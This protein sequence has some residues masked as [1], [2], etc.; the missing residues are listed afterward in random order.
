[1]NSVE[2]LGFGSLGRP[3]V[4]H[5]AMT[6]SGDVFALSNA[7]IRQARVVSPRALAEPGSLSGRVLPGQVALGQTVLLDWPMDAANDASTVVMFSQGDIAVVLVRPD[8]VRIDP[9]YVG[10]HTDAEIIS[11]DDVLSM[12]GK[13]YRVLNPMPG[14]WKVEI[15]ATAAP[16]SGVVD[17][18][19]TGGSDSAIALSVAP[20]SEFISLGS[21]IELDATLVD[22]VTPI[23]G[24]EVTAVIAPPSGPSST[25]PLYDNGLNGD[26]A[27]G[28]G[29]YFGR[30]P[31][32]AES[33]IYRIAVTAKGTSPSFLRNSLTGVQVTANEI[34]PS[35]TNSDAGVDTNG[36]GLYEKL[37]VNVGLNVSRSGS[38]I[39]LARLRAADGRD[40]GQISQTANLTPAD[41][42]IAMLF[43][44]ASI[45]RQRADGPYTISELRVLALGGVT[46]QVMVQTNVY[47]TQAY[48]WRQFQRL[49]ITLGTF[50]DAGLD[51]NGNGQFDVLNV[52]FFVDVTNA[53]TYIVDARLTDL[54]GTEITRATGFY[55]LAAGESLLRLSFDGANIG[56]KGLDGPYLV[57]DLSV[58]LYTNSN[59]ETST[60]LAHQTNVYYYWQFEGQTP[61]LPP[62]ANAGGPYTGKVGVPV[63]F[64]GSGSGDPEGQ[65]LTYSWDF[66]DG[67][68]GSGV[69]PS[70]TYS[71]AGHY[72]VTLVVND[73]TFSSA[74]V[75]TT[76]DI[77]PANLPPVAN[78]GP[79]RVVE[80]EHRV[81]LNGTASY[82]PDGKIVMYKWTQVSG[83]WVRL[84]DANTAIA[85]FR[86]PKTKHRQTLTLVFALNVT[87]NAGATSQ[88]QVTITVKDDH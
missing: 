56:A 1:V 5:T 57:K 38:Y 51:T 27:A 23:P 39:F 6:S 60:S 25:I 41:T 18:M 11:L 46:H 3:P 14:L 28:D 4:S 29:V 75:T 86:A 7:V 16:A 20:R 73:G 50:V 2:A 59:I 77:A 32:A 31:S 24:A 62:T 76:V 33:G 10:G 45:A 44:G 26:I 13:G 43:D 49:P 74:P 40:L 88:D 79:D 85:K 83:P 9:A 68:V 65:P 80:E 47:T 36:D 82:D 52:D 42:A 67:A 34:T 35:G 30:Y 71:S 48:S 37:R 64:N 19:V 66:G 58:Y 72:T 55:S 54:A 53:G 87:D 84:Q 21:P 70:H 17:F 63:V 69:A 61:N 78:A 15:T 22:G 81:T 8:G 12:R